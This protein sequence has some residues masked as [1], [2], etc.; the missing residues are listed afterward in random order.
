MSFALYMI[1]FA[2][3]IGGVAWALVL[4]GVSATYVAITCIILAGLGVITGVSRT[5]TKDISH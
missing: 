3:L 1:G 5:R 2:L 4:A